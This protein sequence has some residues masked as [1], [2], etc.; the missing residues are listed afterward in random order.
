MK[1]GDTLVRRGT[2]H[3]WRNRSDKDSTVVAMHVSIIR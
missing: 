2:K 1:H 3:V